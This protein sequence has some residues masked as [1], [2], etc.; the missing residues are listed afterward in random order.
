MSSSTHFT[1]SEFVQKVVDNGCYRVQGP[2]NIQITGIPYSMYKHVITEMAYTGSSTNQYAQQIFATLSRLFV[3]L[4]QRFDF[5]A[6]DVEIRQFCTNGCL[7][8]TFHCKENGFITFK[9]DPLEAQ[10]AIM[11]VEELQDS[12]NQSYTLLPSR[13]LF[14]S[15]LPETGLPIEVATSIAKAAAAN[16]LKPPKD[17][18]WKIVPH[19][20][21]VKVSTERYK[22]RPCILFLN[23]GSKAVTLHLD[24]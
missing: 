3:P 6:R 21:D 5:S 23:T 4:N 18:K 8:L 15:N 13:G 1:S 7:S 11:D 19:S 16:N 12:L 14:V 24:S 17:F 20:P 22:R 10:C 2:T 9:V